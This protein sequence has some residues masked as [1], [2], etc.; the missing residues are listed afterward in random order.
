[1]LMN[2]K[3]NWLNKH[4]NRKN[5]KS[6]RRAATVYGVPFSTLQERIRGT[7][8]A[9][10]HILTTTEEETLVKWYIPLPIHSIDTLR[11]SIPREVAP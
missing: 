1:M 2:L 6:I 9:N 11:G 4:I 3:F 7:T 10:G 8:R 5:V